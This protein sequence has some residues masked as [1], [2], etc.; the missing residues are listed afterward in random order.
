MGQSFAPFLRGF[1]QFAVVGST[2][3]P[4]IGSWVLRLAQ[5]FNAW[6]TAA[7]SSG[8]AHEWIARSLV[9]LGQTWD[10]LKHLGSAI[11]G[12]F[13]A[14]SGGPNWMPG[15]VAGTKALADWINSPA[16][17]GKLAAIFTTLRNIGSKLWAVL[18]HI[19]PALVDAFSS[20]GAVI[21]TVSVFG[22]VV[23]FAADNL[24]TLT[25]WLPVIIA[26][27]VAYKVAQSA[28]IVV[29]LIRIPLIIAQTIS[30][31]ALAA[32][33]RASM[34]A[35]G[36]ATV[37]TWGLNF[38][39]L[40]SP[41]TWIILGIVALIAVIVLIATKTTWFQW[42]WAR[43]WALLKMV[44]AWFAGPFASFFVQ[45]WRNI[46]DS[47]SKA[48]HWI[49]DKFMWLVTLPA[50]ISA[51]IAKTAVGM[52]DGMVHGL[53]SALNWIISLINTATG[54]LN[55][56][57]IDNINRIPGVSIPHIPEIPYLDKGGDITRTG[58]AVVHK[59]ERV[60]T[61]QTV[62]S[63][64]GGKHEVV[65]RIELAGPAE[66]KRLIRKIVRTDGGGDVQ[67]AFG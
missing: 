25:K 51:G 53:K 40:A 7:R 10:V 37:A 39:W 33:M 55:S 8:R 44:G 11:V 3:L 22:A 31:F 28:G 17:Q 65:L 19:G 24:A 63:G 35:T 41:I 43:V 46:T 23:G 57:V 58:L 47:A 30:N 18:T 50:R 6:A 45:A 15:L 38:A 12:I 20:G 62:A 54:K 13:K 29:D 32:A 52:W 1:S 56:F 64:G 36:E 26:G 16:G 66:V 59:G 48:W 4:G 9:V 61:A 42:I 67:V 2:F 27:F 49:V 5:S 21:N 34:V 60:E 14:G